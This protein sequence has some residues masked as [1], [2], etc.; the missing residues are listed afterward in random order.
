MSSHIRV[1][2]GDRTGV[3]A[4]MTRRSMLLSGVA[5]GAAYGTRTG[6]LESTAADGTIQL[7]WNFTFGSQGWLAGFS[8]YT[9]GMSGLDRI[10]EL[11]ALPAELEM[12]GKL[13]YY[14]QGHNRSDDLFMFLTKQIRPEDGVAP[15]RQYKAHVNVHYATDAQSGCPGIGGSPGDSVYLKAGV[16]AR[17][18]AT[19]LVHDEVRLTLD[20]GN[21]ASGGDE[22]HLLGT[23]AN[24]IPCG[25][26]PT[27]YVMRKHVLYQPNPVRADVH[28]ALWLTVGTDSGFEG[29]TGL[30]YYAMGMALIP[31]ADE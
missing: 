31:V 10:A 15:N 9:L 12:A 25:A 4:V 6:H 14:L 7:A 13:G 18:P 22:L 28:G 17:E 21:Q 16:T 26:E 27:R 29:L 24:G 19:T 23:I 2:K 8:D 30:Y 3:F 1:A 20:K 5:A 11:R